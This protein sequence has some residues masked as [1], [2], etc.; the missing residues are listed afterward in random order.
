MYKKFGSCPGV[1]CHSPPA[2]TVPPCSITC[3]VI[4]NFFNPTLSKKKNFR[5]YQ[6]TPEATRT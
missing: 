2:F 1:R 6:D 5:N 4:A 3:A